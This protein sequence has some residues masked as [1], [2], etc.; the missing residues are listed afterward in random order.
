[1][2]I[3]PASPRAPRSVKILW[4]WTAVSTALHVLFI[5]VLCGFSYVT[6]QHK[7]AAAA[8]KAAADEVIAAKA[9]ADRAA[10]AAAAAAANP[11]PAPAPAAAPTPEPAPVQA[12]KVL[13]IDKVAKP[14]E[15]P[16]SPF[17]SGENDLLKDL[18]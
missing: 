10:K 8:A 5:A 7:Q 2:P 9:E 15:I 17:A 12:E 1:M 11:P 18:K 13:G 3:K 4:K 14:D 16:K 6:W